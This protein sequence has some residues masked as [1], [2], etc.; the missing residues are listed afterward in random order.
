MKN[1]L[2]SLPRAQR[3]IM[4]SLCIGILVV[5]VGVGI[6][7]WPARIYYPKDWIAQ[8]A[9][10]EWFQK[11]AAVR[12][13]G[14]NDQTYVSWLAR[15]GKVMIRARD[16]KT[17]IWGAPVQVAN[18][19]ERYGNNGHDD[20]NT[21]SLL[22]LPDNRLLLF[23]PVHDFSNA[24]S[25]YTTTRPEDISSWSAP[26]QVIKGVFAEWNYPQPKLL[27]NGDIVLFLRQGNWKNATE[28]MTVSHDQ[29][30]TWSSPRVLIDPGA[31]TGTYAFATS[32]GNSLYLTW[33]TRL[34]SGRPSGLFYAQSTDAGATW[35]T[36]TGKELSVPM[37][38]KNSEQILPSDQSV[39]GWDIVLDNQLL[40][41]I[42]M[43]RKTS[44]PE[45]AVAI[46]QN[47]VWKVET[48]TTTRELYSGRSNSDYYSAG[49][50][51][52]P[53]HPDEVVLGAEKEQFTLERWRRTV[54]GDWE[55]VRTIDPP[56]HG[57][58]FRPQFISNDPLS[59]LI[60]LEG[61]YTGSRSGEWEGYERAFLR[62][63]LSTR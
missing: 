42:A 26:R 2:R 21:P 58:Q 39:Y 37:S 23:S 3:Y 62:Y 17:E 5:V 6:A 51:F 59:G 19:E 41:R 49:I 1:P 28:V 18:L 31:G 56:H 53:Q 54:D 25:V 27:A 16:M 7:L 15:D 46:R 9:A 60:W 48:L 20:H 22:A 47:N 12:I 34:K 33:N 29:G 35:T 40:P 4:Y 32:H 24:L 13:Q 57:H 8:G 55:N 61:E 10:L 11:P 36:S 52:D 45:Y 44:P 14:Q 43:M 38:E 30:E 63:S 50:V